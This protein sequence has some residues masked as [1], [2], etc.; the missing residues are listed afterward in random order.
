[1]IFLLKNQIFRVFFLVM[2]GGRC[3]RQI[4]PYQ[5]IKKKNTSQQK[6]AGESAAFPASFN[7]FLSI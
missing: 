4:P 1:M 2:R 7:H 6:D 5:G 3:R